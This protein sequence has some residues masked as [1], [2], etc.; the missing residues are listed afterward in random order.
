LKSEAKAKRMSTAE[1]LRT[2]K[3]TP[4]PA[5]LFSSEPPAPVE[6][7]GAELGRMVLSARKRRD[8]AKKLAAAAFEEEEAKKFAAE[9]A[10]AIPEPSPR[11]KKR[12]AK[13]ALKSSA[14]PA[15]RSIS[16]MNGPELRAELL[17][18]GVKEIHIREVEGKSRASGGG[19]LGLRAMLRDSLR[20]YPGGAPAAMS[21]AKPKPKRKPVG[22]PPL[23]AEVSV[24]MDPDAGPAHLRSDL[25]AVAG[26]DAYAKAMK[27]LDAKRLQQKLE[28][29]V[30]FVDRLRQLRP[31]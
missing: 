11:A 23:P 31:S 24:V 13:L 25:S 28:P 16:K 9:L 5:P 6:E 17:A 4:A 8:E 21:P 15:K 7:G 27:K 26:R 22:P 20:A 19:V 29:L 12:A 14:L 2:L 10:T 30:D 18:R 3:D 1:L